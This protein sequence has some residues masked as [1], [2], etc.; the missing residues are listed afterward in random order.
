MKR[1]EEIHVSQWIEYEKEDVS[2]QIEL[3]EEYKRMF[4]K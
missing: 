3:L 1:K 4:Y 2:E